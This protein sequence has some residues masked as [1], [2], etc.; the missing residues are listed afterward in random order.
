MSHVWFY[1]GEGFVK[2]RFYAGGVRKTEV[3]RWGGVFKT[4]G[5]RGEGFV[6]Q[7]FLYGEGFVKRRVLREGVVRKMGFTWGRGL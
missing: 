6:K 1:V 3:L 5:L 2:R 4:K 7:R